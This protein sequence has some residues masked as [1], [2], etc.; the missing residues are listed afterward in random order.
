MY[1]MMTTVN[2]VVM[3]YRKVVNRVDPDGSHHK[4][5]NISFVFL[6]LYEM[7]DVN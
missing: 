3:I 2:T 5:K 7:M 4:E 6:N 1:N